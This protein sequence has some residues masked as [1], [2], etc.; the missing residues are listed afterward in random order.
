MNDLRVHAGNDPSPLSNLNPVAGDSPSFND[1]GFHCMGAENLIP[2]AQYW[3]LRS[4]PSPDLNNKYYLRLGEFRA[5]TCMS[6]V[7]Y[8]NN[9]NQLTVV[10]N[11]LPFHQLFD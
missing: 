11:A 5:Y 3:A 4:G 8:A 2:S 9:L 7:E 6:L 10:A 1:S